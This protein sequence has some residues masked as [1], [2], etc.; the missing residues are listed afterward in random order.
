MKRSLLLLMP[1]VMSTVLMAQ[2]VNDG[3]AIK[4]QPGA[5]IFCSGNFEN[6]NAGTVSN[7]GKLE[8]QGSFL[9]S[10]NYT[11][12]TSDD[13]LIMS[14]ANSATLNGGSSTLSFLQINK[15]SNTSFIT[16]TGSTT[17]GS[18]LI[19][20]AGT[21][22]TDPLNNTYTLNAAIGVP[23]EFSSGREIIGRVRRTG[24]AN[25]SSIVFNQ[26][27]MTINTA[28]GTSPTEFTVNMIPGA[29]GGD[30]SLNEREVSRKFVFSQ[31]GGTGFTAD[32]RFPYSTTE[33]NTNTENN[34]V[35][36]NMPLT[37]W[38][39]RLTPVTRD[40]ANDWVATTGIPET[41]IT[42]EW[43]LADPKY[44]MNA[45]AVLRGAWT[46]GP[47]MTTALNTAGIIPL[48]QPYNIAPFNYSGT[49]SVATIPNS[50]IVDWVL[51]EFRKPASG[52][53]SDANSGSIIGRKAAFLLNTGAIVDLDGSSPVS[54]DIS[55]QG[56]GYMVVRHRN[57]LGVMSNQLTDVSGVYTNDFR[58]L[59]STYK[60]PLATSQPATA[61]PGSSFLGMW[62]G[63]VNRS[64]SVNSTDVG[65]IK[66]AISILLSG[67]QYQDVNLSNSINSTDVGFTKSTIA[68]LGQTSAPAFTAQ[69]TG[70]TP[71]PT[72]QVI[73]GHLP[74]N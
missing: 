61:L 13:T 8:V 66:A 57:H 25:G 52:L 47:N 28:N 10:A 45:T 1:L 37:E 2:L 73:K 6:K 41:D 53:P 21:L 43:K 4:I 15:A 42:K 30:P 54:F 60:N 51:V 11:S 62:A 50:S 69:G 64:N 74:G 32:A 17:I 65:V 70:T 16:L 29:N 14:G 20:S 3:A 31:L 36:W 59:A 39:G 24:W 68:N 40:G 5:Y 67:Y 58:L 33:L 55:K 27:N 48:T 23:F 7:D 19:Y 18:K 38:N 72:N 12:A 26:P 22:S 44:T 63:D 71:T 9:N 56:A 35:P 49:E 46:S 34:L